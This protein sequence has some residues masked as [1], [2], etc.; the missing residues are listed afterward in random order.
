MANYRID[1]R[2]YAQNP[3]LV[4]TSCTGFRTGK[5]REEGQPVSWITPQALEQLKQG[6]KARNE[7][8][9]CLADTFTPFGP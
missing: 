7:A 2:D 4:P 8:V 3:G 6:A 1:R 9:S 5:K